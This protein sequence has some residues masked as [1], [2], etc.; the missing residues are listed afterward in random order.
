MAMKIVWP[1]VAGVA[2]DP[3]SEKPPS[4]TGVIGGLAGLE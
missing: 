4:S 1:G 2:F 3:A